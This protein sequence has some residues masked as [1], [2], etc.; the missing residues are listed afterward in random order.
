MNYMKFSIII[1]LYNKAP[2]I[3]VRHLSRYSHRRIPKILCLKQYYI[4]KKHHE[5]AKRE[6]MKIDFKEYKDKEYA[7]YL[8]Q[9][10]WKLR[11]ITFLEN[12]YEILLNR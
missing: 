7:S 3:N 2:Y 9:P 1:P 4:S 5:L 12:F 11:I 8:W 6:L 10:L